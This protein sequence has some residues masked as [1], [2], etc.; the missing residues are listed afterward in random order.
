MIVIA[1]GI[2]LAVFI[3]VG[4]CVM[5]AILIGNLGGSP[6]HLWRKAA[7][8][9]IGLRI[10]A[11]GGSRDL[12]ATQLQ[13]EMARFEAAGGRFK[14]KSGIRNGTTIFSRPYAAWAIETWPN[15]PIDGGWDADWKQT[16]LG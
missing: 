10:A 7:V 5:S 1:G 15:V 13:D 14:P 2:L 8:S 6:D 9:E 4:I 12:V 16:A 11:T 3:I